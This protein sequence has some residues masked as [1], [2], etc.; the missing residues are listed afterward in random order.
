MGQ[1]ETLIVTEGISTVSGY[2]LEGATALKN[3]SL[4]STLMMIGL[5]AFKSCPAITYAYINQPEG[6]LMIGSGNTDLTDHLIYKSATTAPTSGSCGANLTWN[7]DTANKQLIITGTGAMT[8]YSA[9]T[10]APWAPYMTEIVGVVVTEGVT[11]VGNYALDGAVSLKTVALPST[12]GNIGLNAFA[13]CANITTAYVERTEGTVDI[14]G[15]NLYL[16]QVLMYK[17]STP[18]NPNPNPNPGTG[19]DDGGSIPNTGLTWTYSPATHALNI[20]GAGAIPNYTSASQAPWAK[21]ASEITA[22]TVQEGIT[23]IGN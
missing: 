20:K 21:Y 15:G 17:A 9:D 5:D 10:K 11:T 16:T 22:I 1:I 8:D 18:S 4:P 2:A 7:Y 13:G 14:R 19:N 3:V 12:M 23:D 6:T